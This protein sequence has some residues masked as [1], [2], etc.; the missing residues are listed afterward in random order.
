MQ[1]FVEQVDRIYITIPTQLLQEEQWIV[2]LVVQ[3]IVHT[4]TDVSNFFNSFC[5]EGGASNMRFC[6]ITSY[7]YIYIFQLL[8]NYTCKSEGT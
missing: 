2:L 7:N 6:H 8:Y 1:P 3:E 5:L 4:G